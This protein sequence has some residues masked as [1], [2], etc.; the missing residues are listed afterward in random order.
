MDVGF[1]GLGRMGQ[2]RT[3][4]LARAIERGEG[5]LD[6]AVI[7]REQARASGLDK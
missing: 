1:I 4:A 7:A 5:A 6:W 2:G 3:A